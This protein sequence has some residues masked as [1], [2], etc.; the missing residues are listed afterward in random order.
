MPRGVEP[1]TLGTDRER[2]TVDGTP[3]RPLLYNVGTSGLFC[4]PAAGVDCRGLLLPV[5]GR[6]VHDRL[7]PVVEAKR[8]RRR[9]PRAGVRNH[10]GTPSGTPRQMRDRL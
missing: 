10:T 9:D 5:N 2:H 8:H 6:R 7:P 4:M 3:F 1:G